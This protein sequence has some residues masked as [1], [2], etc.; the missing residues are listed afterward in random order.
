MRKLCHYKH[1][2]LSLETDK[3][4]FVFDWYDT[5]S[6]DFPAGKQIIW[7]AT[8]GHADHYHP[9]I[10]E[11]GEHDSRFLLSDDIETPADTDRKILPIRPDETYEVED[12][13][14]TTFGSTDR[15]VSLLLQDGD[16]SFFFAGDLNAWIWENDDPETQ[17]MERSDYLIELEKIK[18]YKIDVACVPADPRLGPNYAEAVELFDRIVKPKQIVPLH[19][20]IDYT[21]PTILARQYPGLKVITFTKPRECKE[22]E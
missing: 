18:K 6:P 11:M 15:G 12:F 8:H 3:Y 9:A 20:Q 1:S 17:E 4:F 10:L 13:T 19:F 21:I 2:T 7:I 14:I 16:F 5:H 22:I